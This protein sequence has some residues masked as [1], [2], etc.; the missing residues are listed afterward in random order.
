M[1]MSVRD[2]MQSF[3]PILCEAVLEQ[4]ADALRRVF[5][6]RGPIGF[7]SAHSRQRIADRFAVSPPPR[8]QHL[9][10]DDA[11][12]PDVRALVDLF[13]ACL[14]WTHVG[15]GAKYDSRFCH[16]LCHRWGLR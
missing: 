15:C 7:A 9:A 11:E 1:Q 13:A 2:I 16:K 10:Q 14:L 12:C 8:A 6:K 5:R 4:T 3:F